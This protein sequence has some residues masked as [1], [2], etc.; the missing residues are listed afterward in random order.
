MAID[1][2]NILYGVELQGVYDGIC[3]WI[4]K[5]GTYVNRFTKEG[6][7][8]QW[9]LVEE[10]LAMLRAEDEKAHDV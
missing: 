10:H 1:E 7:P 3:F 4:M 2:G 6:R 9:Q 5:D 8:R